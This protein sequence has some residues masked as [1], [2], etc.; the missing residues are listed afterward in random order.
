MFKS[1]EAYKPEIRRTV[2]KLQAMDRAALSGSSGNIVFRAYMPA[3]NIYAKID[4]TRYDYDHSPEPYLADL[5]GIHKDLFEGRT[6]VRDDVIPF[7]VPFLGI[8]DYSA[9]LAGDVAF[10]PDTS[11]SNPVIIDW[12]DMYKIPPF[13]EAPFFKV[14]SGIMRSLMLALKDSGIP[15]NRGYYSPLDLA[16]ALR[17]QELFTDFFEEEAKVHELLEICTQATIGIAEYVTRMAEEIYQGNG[18]G[19]LFFKGRVSMSEDTACLISPEQYREFGAPYTQRVIDHFGKAGLHS[20]SRALYLVKE[21]CSLRNVCDI[22]IASDPNQPRPV[23][24]LE[25]LI[26]V[27]NGVCLSADCVDFDEIK[28]HIDIMQTGNISLSLPMDDVAQINEIVDY[29]ASKSKI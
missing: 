20:H 22:W 13:G 14:F 27:S 3:D 5:L 8:G 11:W 29:V 4:L 26:A 10:A 17:G 24:K 1:I 19:D 16:Y 7:V 6:E 25:E 18:Y 23:D 21:L 12:D 15:L 2:E 28:R 9:F